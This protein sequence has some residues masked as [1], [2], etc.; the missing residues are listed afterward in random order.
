MIPISE[1]HFNFWALPGLEYNFFVPLLTDQAK[2]WKMDV[3]RELSEDFAQN[4][5]I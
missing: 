1:F 5:E 3:V 2:L 4:L